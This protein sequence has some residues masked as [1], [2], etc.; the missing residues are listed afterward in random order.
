LQK[1]APDCV[2]QLS[3][4]IRLDGSRIAVEN[5]A[6]ARDLLIERWPG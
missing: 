4:A 5:D 1:A 6:Q 3:I 2:T